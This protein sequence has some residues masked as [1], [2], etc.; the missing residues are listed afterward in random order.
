MALRIQNLNKLAAA[1][2]MA[3]QQIASG[4]Q[5]ARETQ[6]QQTIGQMTPEQAA[7]PRLAQSMGAQQAAQASAIQ[8][9][10]QQK[11][12]Q[13][14]V[15]AG[16]QAMVQDKIQKQQE[17]F[18]RSQALSQKNRYLENELARIS[19]S[20][21]DKLL[22][23]QLSFKRDELGRTVWNER[24]LADYKIATAKDEEDFRNY[25][26]EA[27]NL[28]ERRM[29]MLTMAQKKL[30]QILEQGY[31]SNNQKLDQASR[32]KI[33]ETVAALKR[34]QARESA[35]QSS[36]MGMW[37]GAGTVVGA[38][39]GAMI[40]GPTAYAA[41]AAAGAQIGQGVGTAAGAQNT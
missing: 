15:V 5:Q 20:A 10:A 36:N 8:L 1:I 31:I 17:L 27:S 34:K 26:Q 29:K 37:A 12:Q 24:Q 18:T 14:A 21:K 11:T 40:A 30:E 16:Q 39:A 2:P 13:S 33:V 23:Q 9:G 3:N 25:Q 22:D 19:Q 28:S 35:R 4:M 32:L 7:T 38:V 6:L 41:G